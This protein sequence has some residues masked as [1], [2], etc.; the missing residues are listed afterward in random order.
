MKF[1]ETEIPNLIISLLEYLIR[2]AFVIF[3]FNGCKG[4]NWLTGNGARQG[5]N[6]SPSLFKL[7]INEINENI[8]QKSVGCRLN[9]N[10]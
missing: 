7:Y 2:N 6:L 1:R 3:S 4:S 8:L 9:E 5:G 10:S